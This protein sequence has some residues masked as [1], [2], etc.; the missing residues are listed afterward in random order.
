VE[1]SA[2]TAG[3]VLDLR[4][5]DDIQ[6]GIAL[7]WRL[8]TLILSGALSEGERLP[9]VRD[10]A[11]A[12]GVN[13]NTARAVYARLEKEG[14]AVSRQGDGTFVAP[15]LTPA[16]E[17]QDLAADAA[18]AA[19]ARGIDPRDLARAVYAGSDPA[20]ALAARRS[21]REQVARLEAQLAAY[22]E[23]AVRLAAERGPSFG[24]GRIT[25]LGEIE[26]VRDELVERLKQVRLA[27]AAREEEHGI[28]R[29][30]LEAMT[31]DPGAHRWDTVSNEE[32]GE[33]G[34]GRHEVRAVA[35]PV[36]ALMNWWR[37]KVSSGCPLAE[38]A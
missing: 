30:R 35:G 29:R 36:G 24:Q 33:P 7:G 25:D 34:C 37:I 2:G 3:D 17:L 38:S 14:L 9:G 1:Q 12:S 23:D 22:P 19:L 8:R 28:A 26:A 15:N 32:L 6:V 4:R 21:L 16:P 27:A 13:T 10:F 5:D 18:E 20:D 11:A 31:A